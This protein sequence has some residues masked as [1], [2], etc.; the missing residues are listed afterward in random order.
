MVAGINGASNS[1]Q[2]KRNTTKVA[3]SPAPPE[4]GSGLWNKMKKT[5]KKVKSITAWKNYII[6]GGTLEYEEWKNQ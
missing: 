1:E 5:P 3:W 2:N 6:N 4:E